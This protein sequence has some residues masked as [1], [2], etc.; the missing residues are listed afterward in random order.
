MTPVITLCM[1]IQPILGWLHCGQSDEDMLVIAAKSHPTDPRLAPL[2]RLRER[3]SL[4]AGDDGRPGGFTL[5]TARWSAGAA[6][7]P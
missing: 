6:C 3:Q 5:L 7:D 2:R 1:V 4:G